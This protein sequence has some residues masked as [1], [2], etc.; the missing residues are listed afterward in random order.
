[1]YFIHYGAYICAS[2][3]IEE[4]VQREFPIPTANCWKR[5]EE[6]RL[7][8]RKGG[9]YKNKEKEREREWER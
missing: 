2:Y 8:M 3:V 6:K 7:S 1:M 9:E 5:I 4:S